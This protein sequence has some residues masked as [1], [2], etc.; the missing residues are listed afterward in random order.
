[1]EVNS[2]SDNNTKS[3][4]PNKTAK[5]V[6][7]MVPNLRMPKIN[8]PKT[9]RG[10]YLL[11][12]IMF[13]IVSL[14]SGFLGGY[15]ESHNSFSGVLSNSL[16][17]QKQIVTSDSQLISEIAKTVGPSVV[18]IN[19][20]ITTQ[21]GSSTNSSVYGLFGLS[22][23]Q[24]QEQAAGTGIIISSNGLII[25]NRHVVPVGTT[26]VSVTLSNGVQL[27][28]I[29]I[30]GRSSN[31]SLDIA[32][33]KINNT[34]GQKL[35]PAILGDSS[36]MQVGTPV[37][38]IG[39]A[40]G[41]FQNTV[42][43]GIISGYGR[44]ITASAASGGSSTNLFGTGS[45]TSGNSSENLS[46]LFQTDAAINEGNSGGPLVNLN[47]QVIG[48][49]VAI[50]G[51]AQNIGFSIP[52]NDVKGIVNQILKGG[53]F[54]LPYLGIRYIPLTADVANAYKLSVQNGAYIPPTGNL[55]QQSIVSGSPASK[56][57]L[58][59]NDIITAI[60]GVQI[61]QGNS[62][63]SLLYQYAPG[64]HINLTVLRD[65]KYIHIDVTLQAAP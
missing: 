3:S 41:Q 53:N 30:I 25:T 31:P 51:N 52:I 59:I 15:Y 7:I 11:I 58:K 17:N 28:D 10:K 34:D 47:G 26:N 24:Q 16:S 49:N 62:L 9:E 5:T 56:A 42:T 39:N 1:M 40:L 29:S 54:T 43:S 20:I 57:G 44:N 22:Q 37:V 65:G 13:I 35:T 8:G 21:S 48:I 27:K 38:A 33:L 36:Q 2:S 60:N 63:D 23:P 46:D 32:F 4:R 14:L 64:D 6:T 18:S 61:N 19:D 50:A 45:A 12:G 55:S